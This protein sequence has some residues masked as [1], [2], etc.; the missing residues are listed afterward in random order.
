MSNWVGPQHRGAMRLRRQQR[1]T[2]AELRNSQA[3]PVERYDCGHRHSAVTYQM[4]QVGRFDTM[5][6]A[7]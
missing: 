7:S 3:Q 4:C 6:G 2:E 1:R 5:R